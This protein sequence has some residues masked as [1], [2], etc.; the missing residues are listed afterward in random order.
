MAASYSTGTALAAREHLLSGRPLTRLE[1]LVL[2]G[3]S[4]LPELIYEMKGQGFIIKKR[5]VPYAAAMVR[6]NEFAVLKP[7]ANL[8][9]RE[10]MLTEYWV[11]K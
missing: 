11:S 10:I 1:A 6:V 3:L 9:I 5:N 2:F 7:P 4:N 8:P